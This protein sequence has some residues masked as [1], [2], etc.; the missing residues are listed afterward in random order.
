MLNLVSVPNLPLNI[1]IR[2]GT[3]TDTCSCAIT[4]PLRDEDAEKTTGLDTTRLLRESIH[5]SV[6]VCLIYTTTKCYLSVLF[7]SVLYHTNTHT[8]R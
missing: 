5:L 7:K 6:L 2:P 3:Y 1:Y 8:H 4:E